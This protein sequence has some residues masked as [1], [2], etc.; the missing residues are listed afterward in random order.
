MIF[1]RLLNNLI[2]IENKGELIQNLNDR[3]N[4][5]IRFILKIIN[6]CSNWA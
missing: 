6:Y 3:V 4:Y 1:N 5:N 2:E